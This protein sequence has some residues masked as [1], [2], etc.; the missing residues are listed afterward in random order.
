MKM[1]GS[2]TKHRFLALHKRTALSKDETILYHNKTSYKLLHNKKPD[3]SYLYV[4]GAL[5]YPTNDTED[6]RKLKPK[7]DIGIF[8]D[9]APAKKAFRIYNKRTRLIIEIIHVEFDELTAMASEQFSSGP[10]PQLMTH[11][12]LSS[13]LVPNSPSPTS[14]FDE[15]FNPPPS[16]ASPVLTVIAPKHADSTG[17]PSAT[18]I[19][20]DALSPSTL[21]IPQESQSSVIPFGVEEH[22]HDIEVAHLDNDP[23]FSVLIPEPNSKGSS[24]KDVIP[25]NVHSVSQ[26]HED[27]KVCV[28]QPDRFVDQDNPNHVFKLKKALYG[29]KQPLRAWYGLL[30]SFLL[31][32][33]FSKGVVDPTLFTRK[34]DTYILLD[35]CIALTAFSYVDHA[36]YQDTRR[37]TSGSLQLFGD[38]LVSWSSKKHKSTT[39]SCTEAEYITLSGCCSQILWMR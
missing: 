33:K 23:F 7:A 3:L 29:I 13:G 12:T 32:K 18:T 20:Q 25:N 14:M 27:L 21:Q 2:H 35:S 5:C 9:Y 15:Y 37:S 6:L 1:S 28:S 39:I 11:E 16:V 17:P 38:R 31:S 4:F 24:S 19:E 10:E 36:G 26:P 34:E 30:S 22:F 8:V